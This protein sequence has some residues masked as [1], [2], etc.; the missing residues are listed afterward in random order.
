MMRKLLVISIDSMVTEDLPIIKGLPNMGKILAHSSL[1][2]RMEST[3][4]TLTHAIH[5]GI[6]TG[7]YPERHGI[8]CNEQF[9]PGILSPPWYEE[10]SCLKVPT[11]LDIA[12]SKGLKTASIC[13][14]LTLHANLPLIV[15]RAGIRIPPEQKRQVAAARSTPGLIDKMAG[16]LESVW[17]MP[18]YEGADRLSYRAAAY[19]AE[20]DKP[21]IMYIHIILIDHLRHVHGVFSP[22]LSKGY[23]FLD[24]ELEPLLEAMERAGTLKNTIINFTS[25]HG[26]LN[27]ERVCSLNRFFREQGFLHVDAGGHLIDW[28]AYAHSC[29]LS[30]QIYTK[31]GNAAEVENLLTL[32]Q[33]ELGIGEVL[34][35]DEVKTRYHVSDGFSF[36][37]ETDGKTAFSSDYRAPLFCTPDSEDYRYSR[38]THGHQPEKGVQPTF[39]LYNPF[40]ASPVML[41]QGRIID[42]APTLARLM[43]FSMEHCDGQPIQ[44][45]LAGEML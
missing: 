11:L 13:W 7:C 25:D 38:A 45:L 34:L 35:A 26:H 31:S 43:G 2:R 10:A 19:L 29:G 28:N 15:H 4:P 42:Q 21:D 44:A 1:V 36:M 27:V 32:H 5:A 20:H 12:A 18:H 14:P 23:A 24:R 39:F 22:E 17:G 6:I 33:E 3:Y 40:Q 37:V 41:E 8:I 16:E 9:Q 30:A